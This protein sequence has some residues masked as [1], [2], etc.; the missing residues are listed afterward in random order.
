[1]PKRFRTPLLVLLMLFSMRAWAEQPYVVL[2]S[3]DGFRYD[4]A[5]RYKASHILA[6]RDRGA[7]AKSL[8]PVYP[9]LT[10]PNHTSIITGLYPAHHGIVDNNFYDPQR[11][12]SFAFNKVGNVGSWYGGTP[13]WVLA[14][15][16][17]MKSATYFWPGSDGAIAGV[18]PSYWFPFDDKVPNEKRIDQLMEWLR[19]PAE[20][21]PHFITMYFS[22]VDHA[23]HTFGPESP[24]TGKAVQTVDEI[25]GRIWEGLQATHLPINLII[26]S[27]HGMQPVDKGYI[28]LGQYADLTGIRDNTAAGTQKLLYVADRD[29]AEATYRALKGKSPLFDIFRRAETPPEWHYRDNPR[30]GDLVITTLDSGFLVTKIA[31]NP[32]THEPRTPPVGAHGY[33]PARFKTMHGIFYAIGPNI[34]AAQ[35]DSFENI[36]IYPL[37]VKILG[38]QPPAQLDGSFSVLES[39]YKP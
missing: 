32:E 24:E 17:G 34:G 23:G 29:K 19:L 13:L 20:Q 14:E 5:E 26:V 8:V 15:R 30:I 3:L 31:V 4:Y 38:L 2:I 27:D 33:D 11:N 7:S 9:S 6:I 16:Q 35:V 39:I 12:D 18:R 36:H 25:V 1:M 22:E 21:R 10:F 28:V 37:I